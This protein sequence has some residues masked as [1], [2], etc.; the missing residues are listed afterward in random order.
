M[1][2]FLPDTEK[3]NENS[4]NIDT[5]PVRDMLRVIND[6]DKT[7][8]FAV[9][10][11]I[12]QIAKAVEAGEAALRGGGRMIY[13]GCG[14]SG[15]LG[16]LDASECPP[17]YGV[18]P[19]LVLGIIAGG[20]AALR[21]SVEGAEDSLSMPVQ[22][23][24][25]VSVCEKDLVV[26]I[27]ASGKAPYVLSGLRFARELGAKTVLIACA[28]NR[29]DLRAADIIIAV[30]TGAEAIT[31]STRMK[32][33]TAQKMILNMLSTGVMIRMGK[34]HGNLM[35]DVQPSNEKLMDRAARIIAETTGLDYGEAGEALKKSGDSVKCAIVMH[36]LTVDRTK[37]EKLLLSHGGVIQRVL[38][39]HDI[40]AEGK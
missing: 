33:G 4:E 28:Q 32:A 39:A 21:K 14:T 16:V 12:G 29:L 13:I 36:K 10:R 40:N 8:A 37:A 22:D 2:N 17:T 27:S 5:L 1:T 18:D 20:D 38:D 26:G 3:R 9:E 35:V 25:R 15:R 31:G 11:E 6:E 7:I 23:L 19:D 30:N 24:K 34:V